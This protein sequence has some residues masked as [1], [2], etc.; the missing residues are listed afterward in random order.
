MQLQPAKTMMSTI[1]KTEKKKKIE[2]G[3]KWKYIFILQS[4]LLGANLLSSAIMVQNFTENT[5][6][7]QQLL[8]FEETM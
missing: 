7:C 1:P 4:Y 6:I 8:A 2:M 3:E 5:K